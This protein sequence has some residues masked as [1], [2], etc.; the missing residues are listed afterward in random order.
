MIIVRLQGGL[1]NQM[2][3][4]AAAYSHAS[5]NRAKLA[6]DI[7]LLQKSKQNTALTARDYALSV[8]PNIKNKVK[9]Y[10]DGFEKS[11]YS[12]ITGRKIWYEKDLRYDKKMHAAGNNIIMHGYFQNEAYFNSGREA[13]LK[14]FEFPKLS[15]KANSYV[16]KISS[17]NSVSVHVRRGDYVSD[18]KTNS[19][20]GVL[21]V[22]YYNRAIKKISDLVDDPL[23][24]FISDD[25]AWCEETFKSDD[26]SLFIKDL[27]NDFEDMALMSLC[28]HNIIANSSFSWWGAWLNNNSS[29]IVIAPDQWFAEA[30]K[31]NEAAELVPKSWVRI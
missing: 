12:R 28:K 14:Q 24:V 3:Q 16:S 11:L 31:N 27:D 5:K 2:F 6:I 21:D 25:V 23:F 18:K 22:K 4:Y 10:P 8:F 9:H 20:H 17:R 1:G 15:I 30:K 29:K 7:S 13:I 26:S 19:V